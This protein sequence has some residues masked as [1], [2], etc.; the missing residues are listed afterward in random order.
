M[1]NPEKN[2][3]VAS[4]LKDAAEKVVAALRM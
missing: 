3:A 1:E 4:G 2:F